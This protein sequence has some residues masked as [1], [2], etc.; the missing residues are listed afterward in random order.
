MVK[1]LNIIP[2]EGYEVDEQNSTF[3]KIVFKKKVYDSW[4]DFVR[5][6][7]RIENEYFINEQGSIDRVDDASPRN[8]ND[9]TLCK[10]YRDAVR[11]S[12]LFKL[13]RIQQEW[14]KDKTIDKPYWTPIFDNVINQWIPVRTLFLTPLLLMFPSKEL[15]QAFIEVNVFLLNQTL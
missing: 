13:R 11:F 3:Q 6:H 9:I 2:P 10:T 15:C 1:S 5:A 8:I 7:P 12:A 14:V 4:S